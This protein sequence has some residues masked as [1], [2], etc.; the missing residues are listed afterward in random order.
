MKNLVIIVFVLFLVGCDMQD[1]GLTRQ[2][3]IAAV[4]EC[5]AA[6]MQADVV[7]GIGRTLVGVNCLPKAVK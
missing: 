5:E 1:K 4:K 2:E 6:G 3:T 7:V